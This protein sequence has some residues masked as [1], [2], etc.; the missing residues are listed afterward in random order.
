MIRKNGHSITLLIILII[1]ISLIAGCSAGTVTQGSTQDNNINNDGELIVHF[2]DVGQADSILIQLPSGEIALIDGGNRDD[3]ELIIEYLE[4]HNVSRINYLLATHPHEDHIGGLPEVVKSFQIDNVYMPNKSATTKIFESFITELKAKGLKATMAK[5]GLDIID[6]NDLKFTILAPNSE[7]YSE[8]NEYSIVCKL[9]YKDRSFIFTGDAE[10]VSEKEMIGKGLDLSADVLKVGHHGGRTSSTEEFLDCVDPKLAVISV[11][12]ENDY[13][14]PHQET[15]NRLEERNISIMKTSESGTIVIS[16]DGQNI[17]NQ[18]VVVPDN[19]QLDEQNNEED[20]EIIIGNKNT[21]VY[22]VK[23]CNSLPK[24]ENQIIFNSKED[25]EKA[26][27]RPD[28]R[29]V[30]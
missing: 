22:H 6:S 18:G 24:A 23:S 26:G 1:S 9:V 12:A 4:K 5:G 27:Y 20:K 7:K 11:A 16:T 10:G 25:A 8:T 14:H 13:G 19:V 3:S 2:I 29:C 28:S 17:N 15:I 21:K 30:K